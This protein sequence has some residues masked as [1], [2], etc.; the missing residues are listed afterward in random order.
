MHYK[1]EITCSVC[2]NVLLFLLFFPCKTGFEIIVPLMSLSLH[3]FSSHT[4]TVSICYLC[5]SGQK[6]EKK[7]CKEDGCNFPNRV[8]ISQLEALSQQTLTRHTRTLSSQVKA[9]ITSL[10][11]TTACQCSGRW[12]AGGC[13]PPLFIASRASGCGASCFLT[14]WHFLLFNRGV[15]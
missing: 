12:W 11:S 15:A 10:A 3:F 4:H 5:H 9:A 13:Q 6:K 1:S 7:R 8:E 14:Q 2:I